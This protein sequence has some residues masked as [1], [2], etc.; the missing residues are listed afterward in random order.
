MAATT[1][2]NLGVSLTAN[3]KKFLRGMQRAIRSLKR[4]AKAAKHAARVIAT[5]GV[6]AI[7]AAA[8]LAAVFV[9]VG[10]K[11]VRAFAAL[12]RRAAEV[13]TLMDEWNRKTL[14]GLILN[15]QK[16]A[17]AFGQSTDAIGKAQYDIVSAG[18]LDVSESSLIM[19][20]SLKAATA[21]LTDAGT[22]AS[23]I[24]SSL[25]G[26]QL[27]A[28]EATRIS[29]ILFT[30]VKFGRTTFGELAQ[31]MG[32]VIPT[33][34]AAGVSFKELNAALA[35]ATLGGLD[36]TTAVTSLNRLILAMAAPTSAAAR[37]MKAMGIVT[38][39]TAG[40]LLSLQGVIGQF[41]GKSIAQIK[42][43]TGDI[44]G[45]RGL[46][47]LANN[48][49]TFQKILRGFNNTTG[50]TE[51]A[52]KKMSETVSFKLQQLQATWETMWQRIGAGFAPFLKPLQQIA[53][54][55]ADK[56]VPIIGKA[57]EGLANL[58]SK[59]DFKKLLESAGPF[60]LDM[61]AKMANFFVKMKGFA[62]IGAA[63]VIGF[64]ADFRMGLLVF[65]QE[66]ERAVDKTRVILAKLFGDDDSRR[67]ATGTFVTGEKRRA[68][69]LQALNNELF[70][71][72]S[73][74]ARMRR[75]GQQDL[76]R[77]S[78]GLPGLAV[79]K[80][81]KGAIAGWQKAAPTFVEAIKKTFSVVG[82]VV[83]KIFKQSL[84]GTA[85]GLAGGVADIVRK[86]LATGP[87][88]GVGVTPT[89]FAGAKIRGSREAF[90]AIIRNNVRRKTREELAA[91]KALKEARKGTDLLTSINR[92]ISA[93]VDKL[94]EFVQGSI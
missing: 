36:T 19:T 21:G 81:I 53:D 23:L 71:A 28:S 33:A 44:R 75:S 57:I 38:T 59:I 9:V 58:I 74:A 47:A 32:M 55:I 15:F 6:A 11:G 41:R 65:V 89:R 94:P 92:G 37:A 90:S 35:T 12:E 7:A 72:R 26:Y 40:R 27:G 30:T 73:I 64:F 8:A 16:L 91:E 24:I 84:L 86:L 76:F 80:W 10:V 85:L 63:A 1:I 62:K 34:K 46:L 49:E 68:S 45:A 69:E 82:T 20:Q 25:R 54:V 17:R 51:R 50:A 79:R 77:A 87:G 43:L 42:E 31:S 22:A 93:V 39:D 48:F 3:T 18:F 78:L 70:G 67:A 83:G 66:I 56:I 88:A 13:G 4:M 61:A 29:D 2:A 60:L 5:V 52:F 14:R